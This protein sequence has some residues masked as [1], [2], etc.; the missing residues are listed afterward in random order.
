MKWAAMKQEASEAHLDGADQVHLRGG[1]RPAF[2]P[3]GR[4]G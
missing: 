3:F 1:C 4:G 2:F